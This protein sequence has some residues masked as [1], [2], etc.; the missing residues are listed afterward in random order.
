MSRDDNEAPPTWV[1][2]LAA[3][4]VAAYYLSLAFAV[5]WIVYEVLS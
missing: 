5:L 1:W 3:V 4:A 2:V